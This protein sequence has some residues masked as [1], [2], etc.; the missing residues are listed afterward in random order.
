MR[1]DNNWAEI[2]NQIAR[3]A[4]DGIL[5]LFQ[6]YSASKDNL[7]IKWNRPCA[8]LLLTVNRFGKDSSSVKLGSDQRWPQKY[9]LVTVTGH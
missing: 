3:G 7:K 6:A 2:S 8:R 5:D 1:L 9:Y 4:I